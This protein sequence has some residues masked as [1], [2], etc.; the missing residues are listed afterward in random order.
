[1]KILIS[2]DDFASRVL[3]TKLLGKMGQCDVTVNGEET[4]RAFKLAMVAGEPYDLVCLDIMMPVLDGIDALKM[5]RDFEDQQGIGGLDRVKVIMVT[6]LG[7]SKNVLEAFKDGCEA[8][9]VKP[10]IKEKLYG[11][12][13]KLGL[14]PQG[15]E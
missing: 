7:D 4:V 6:A 3:L 9:I 15:A 14:S 2:E 1:M 12:I 11:E 10:I 8:Y 5:I 13:E